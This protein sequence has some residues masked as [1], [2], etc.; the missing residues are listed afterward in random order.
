MGDLSKGALIQVEINVG[1]RCR[2]CKCYIPLPRGYPRQ[3]TKCEQL[4]NYNGK[5]IHQTLIRCPACKGTFDVD[6]YDL[7]MEDDVYEEGD[8]DIKCKLCKTVFTVETLIHFTF[9]SPEML[10]EVDDEEGTDT[11]S[12]FCSA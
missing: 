7:D 10:T 5:V 3:C 9:E 12:G 2:S 11:G 8:H 6:P 4:D 1:R